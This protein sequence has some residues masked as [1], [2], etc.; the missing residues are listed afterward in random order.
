MKKILIPALALT[1]YMTL[2]S[3]SCKHDDDNLNVTPSTNNTQVAGGQ[4]RISYYYDKTKEETSDYSGNTFEF[5]SNNTISVNRNGQTI[6]GT[7]NQVSDDGKQKMVLTFN[8]TDEKVLELADDWVIDSKTDSEI[9]L[10]GDSK[11][12]TETLHFVK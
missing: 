10:S 8:T 6:S 4:W 11:T 9:K 2:T 7:W 5:N 1:L 12:G 3:S